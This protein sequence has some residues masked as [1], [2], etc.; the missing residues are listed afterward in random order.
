MLQLRVRHNDHPTGRICTVTLHARNP[1]K[2]QLPPQYSQDGGLRRTKNWR[3]RTQTPLR[4]TRHTTDTSHPIPR[5][6]RT[7]L[8]LSLLIQ[9][10]WAQHISGTSI[11]I[12]EDPLRRLPH[13]SKERWIQSLR[14]F[15][16]S[17]ALHLVLTDIQTR[18]PKRERDRYIM[19]IVTHQRDYTL[20][21]IEQINMCHL[22]LKANMI[23]DITDAA[24][25]R[26]WIRPSNRLWPKQVRPTNTLQ[27]HS[28]L[29]K[30]CTKTAGTLDIPLG[31][32]QQSPLHRQWHAFHD[33]ADNTATFK[34]RS[35][36]YTTK[37]VTHQRHQ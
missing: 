12:L 2:T 11:P 23:S 15:L 13:L 17:S 33:S 34:S 26:I 32:C 8:D 1:P 9:L 4:R 14:S 20:P 18:R 22:Y 29:K 27:W 36:W 16:D 37:H 5:L 6:K 25:K 30:L 28:F 31:R 19:D 35:I 3:F 7:H 10:K 21:A 24:G